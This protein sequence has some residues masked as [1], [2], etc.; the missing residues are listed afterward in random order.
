MIVILIGT[1]ALGMSAPMISR[2]L[3]NETLTNTQMQ[4]IQ[5]QI[6]ALKS[7]T[8]ETPEGAVMFFLLR[9]CP[10]GWYPIND[11]VSGGDIS[12]LNGYFPRF[13]GSFSPSVD[14]YVGCDESDLTNKEC[15]NFSSEVISNEPGTIYR[16]QI[17][18]ITGWGGT[19]NSAS[20]FYGK[21][22]G[23]FSYITNHGS[24]L[25]TATDGNKDWQI[26]FSAANVVPTGIENRP[27]AV[28]LLGCVKGKPSKLILQKSEK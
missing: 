7:R 24:K 2:Q 5:R 23:A 12:G 28:S 18:N 16:D 25:R 9:S 22:D 26:H 11:Y 4:V 21:V 1:I 14:G 27:L 17:R 15:K 3:K 10:D 8:A 19:A 20:V 6:D 13:A